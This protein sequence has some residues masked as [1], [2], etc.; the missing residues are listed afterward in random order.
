MELIKVRSGVINQYEMWNG[1]RMVRISEDTEVGQATLTTWVNYG[2]TITRS[3]SYKT[4][5]G[6]EKW[7]RE[8]L[9]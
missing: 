8:W 5:K 1:S 2:E 7:A 9:S 4:V 3:R 6:A